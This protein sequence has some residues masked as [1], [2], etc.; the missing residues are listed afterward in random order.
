MTTGSGGWGQ[1]GFGKTSAND[2]AASV[3]TPGVVFI[4]MNPQQTTNI[5]GDIPTSGTISMD[6]FYD[7]DGA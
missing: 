3:G 1:G 5:N 4:W 7:G 2:G 6:D